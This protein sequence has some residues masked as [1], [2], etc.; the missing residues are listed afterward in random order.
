M[1]KQFYIRRNNVGCSFKLEKEMIN[2]CYILDEEKA[3]C[4]NS[5]NIEVN[6]Y[7]LNFN[8]IFH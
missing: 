4:L 1:G 3:R 7:G 5:I 8:E 6:I 2:I